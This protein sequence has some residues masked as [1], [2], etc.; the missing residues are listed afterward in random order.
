[1]SELRAMLVTPL[2]GP[3]AGFGRATAAALELWAAEAADLPGRFQRVRLDLEDAH[4]DPAAAMRRGL[5]SGPHLLFGPYGSG[6]TLE[7]LGTTQRAVWNHGGAVSTIRWPVFPGVVNVLSPASSYFRGILEVVRSVEP[8]QGQR[9]AILHA[10]SGFGA[11]VAR[12]AVDWA[13]RLGFQASA[14]PFSRGEAANLASRVPDADVFLVAGGFEDELAAARALLS[15]KWRA[16]GLVGAGVEEVLAS[17]GPAREGLLGPSQWMPAAA[18]VPNEGPDAGWFETRYRSIT[19]GD[20]PY[21]AAQ[22]MAAGVLAARCLREAQVLEDA[23]LLAAARRL[24]CRTLYGEFRLDPATGL[25]VGH[26]VLTVQW[27]SGRRRI[28]W[29]LERA[30]RPLAY[31]RV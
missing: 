16:V 11:D 24:A 19:G 31:P 20:A 5:A 21:P 30:E 1:M 26:E 17:L 13:R 25:Q 12:G 27:Q 9:V 4:P 10:S 18:P 3:L 22:A 8:E 28:V 2:S 6:P 29:P 23:A 15:R 14:N 7:V